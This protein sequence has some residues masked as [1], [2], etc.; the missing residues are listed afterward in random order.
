MLRPSG[1]FELMVTPTHGLRRGLQIFRHS[2]ATGFTGCERKYFPLSRQ[3]FD[4]AN[5]TRLRFRLTEP[6]KKDFHFELTNLLN[7]CGSC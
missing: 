3:T 2:A 7:S 5:P 6:C 4:T 1:A